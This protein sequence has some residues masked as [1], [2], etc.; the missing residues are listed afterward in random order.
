MQGHRIW[1]QSKA[2]MRLQL[3]I[4]SNLAPI[5]HR[6]RDIAFVWDDRQTDVRW[7]SRKND[8]I[9]K[10]VYF[11]AVVFSIFL[12]K[13]PPTISRRR[14]SVFGVSF[15]A[16]VRPCGITTQTEC[17]FR[18]LVVTRLHQRTHPIMHQ[19]TKLQQNLAMHR[20]VND[21][22][23]DFPGLFQGGVRGVGE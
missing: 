9:S 2:H 10:V 22:S 15:R 14:H 17:H 4:N 6:F 1:Y 7:H 12:F 19:P 3:V 8:R 5:L 13:P 11:T 21:D 20:W 18:P 16:Y 23:T